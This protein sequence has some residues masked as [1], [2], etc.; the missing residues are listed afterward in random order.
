MLMKPGMLF[1]REMKGG[2]TGG[3]YL[4]LILGEAAGGVA[5]PVRSRCMV[6]VL[7][8]LDWWVKARGSVTVMDGSFHF[9]ADELVS[10]P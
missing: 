2:T 7:D 1:R 4:C 3:T 6:V 10:G 5:D 8:G 9:S